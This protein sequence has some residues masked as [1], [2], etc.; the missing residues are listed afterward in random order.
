MGPVS[1]GNALLIDQNRVCRLGIGIGMHHDGMHHDDIIHASS[2]GTSSSSVRVCVRVAVMPVVS[3]YEV[4]PRDTP[5]HARA[6]ARRARMAAPASA[7]PPGRRRSHALASPRSGSRMAGRARQASA[8]GR[9]AAT[10]AASTGG[11][12]AGWAVAWGSGHTVQS[13]SFLLK[14]SSRPAQHTHCAA[15]SVAAAAAL[16]LTVDCGHESHDTVREPHVYA[17]GLLEVFSKKRDDCCVVCVGLPCRCP[18][19]I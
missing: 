9:T 12:G 5:H 14:T 18:D 10:T 1:S 4:G 7:P 16:L 15:V 3:R 6:A 19:T 13:S 8:G 11:W 17:A 2:P